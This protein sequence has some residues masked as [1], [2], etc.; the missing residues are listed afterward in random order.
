MRRMKKSY[1]EIVEILGVPKGTLSS[2]FNRQEWSAQIQRELDAATRPIHRARFAAMART[3]SAKFAALR[4]AARVD[5]RRT[6]VRHM[7]NSLFSTGLALYWG[8]GEKRLELGRL[9]IANVDPALLWT[10]TRFLTECCGTPHARLRAW[11]LLYPDLNE[12]TCLRYW[13]RATAIPRSQFRK[14][15]VIIGRSARRRVTHGV[16]TVFVCE[17]LL[18]E[19]LDEWLR[20]FREELLSRK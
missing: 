19:R 2:W 9:R 17:R 16:C 13:S 1:R 5:A 3:R 7:R 8:E 12:E 20:C 10:F 18:C 11:V 4:E 6:F 15:Q 14:S